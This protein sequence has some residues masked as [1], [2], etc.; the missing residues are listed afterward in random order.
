MSDILESTA[1]N[2]RLP[3]EEAQKY[4]LDLHQRGRA[5]AKQEPNVLA[6]LKNIAREFRGEEV[7]MGSQFDVKADGPTGLYIAV[8]NGCNFTD[9]LD[10]FI[11]HLLKKFN[12]SGFVRFEW[13]R[14]CTRLLPRC[15]SGGGCTH[16]RR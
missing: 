4:A 10:L 2:F 7:L 8:G 12:P 3:S 14:T 5:V 15:V 11:Q 1:L 6:E 9:A 13:G 16:Y